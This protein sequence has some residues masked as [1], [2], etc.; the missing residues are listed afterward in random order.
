MYPKFVVL[1]RKSLKDYPIPNSN[2]IIPA[3]TTIVLPAHAL[4]RDPK[5]YRDPER[6]LPERFNPDNKKL[7]NANRPYLSFGIGPRNCIG[8]HFGRMMCKVALITM[9]QDYW[10][11]EAKVT[12]PIAG[13]GL[14]LRIRHRLRK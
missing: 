8:M 14:N 2:M 11:S 10:F 6:F 1:V 9:L 3:G 5:Y 13:L 7:Y 4:Q 12:D